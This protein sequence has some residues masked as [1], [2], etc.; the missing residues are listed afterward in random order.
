MVQFEQ[1][2]TEVMDAVNV[3]QEDLQKPMQ[4]LMQSPNGQMKMQ[5]AMMGADMEP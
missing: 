1:T 3:Q 4:M 2:L 5:A